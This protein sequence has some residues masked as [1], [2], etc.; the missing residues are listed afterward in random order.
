MNN[1]YMKV[2]IGLALGAFATSASAGE[3][4]VIVNPKNPTA[5][6]TADQVE[7][8]FLGK[9]ASIPGGGT[10]SAVDQADNSPVRDEFYQKAS[11]KTAAQVKAIWSRLIFSGKSTP[12]KEVAS[13]ADVK[14][15]VAGNANAI[16]Y[17]EKS[18]VDASVKVVLSLP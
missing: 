13:S 8:I 6:M 10:A 16:G 7:Q 14:K 11:G 1:S 3:L 2:I 5:A 17:I 12:P 4:A 18:A 15:F 9:T